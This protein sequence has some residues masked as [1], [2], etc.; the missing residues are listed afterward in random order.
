MRSS[1]Q[2]RFTIEWPPTSEFSSVEPCARC[3]GATTVCKTPGHPVQELR[4]CPAC[5]KAV[6]SLQ[7]RQAAKGA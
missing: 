7:D 1:K 2:I 6:A 4:F 3:N 5:W